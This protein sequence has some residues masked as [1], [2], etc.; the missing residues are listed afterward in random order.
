MGGYNDKLSV[1]LEK[2]IRKMRDIEIN[3]ERFKLLKD[4]V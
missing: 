3:E 2:V 4:Q 1:L